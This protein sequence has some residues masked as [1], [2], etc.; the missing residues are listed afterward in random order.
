MRASSR[1]Q[2]FLFMLSF[3]GPH[4]ITVE[5]ITEQNVV[6]VLQSK[7]HDRSTI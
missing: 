3:P 5:V 7:I 1:L 2:D 4:E 6:E